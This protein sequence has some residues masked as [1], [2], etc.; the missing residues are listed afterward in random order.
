MI[1]AVCHQGPRGAR[2]VLTRL[3]LSKLREFRPEAGPGSE[4]ATLVD[5]MRNCPAR[6]TE[7]GGAA[8]AEPVRQSRAG[9]LEPS[10][11]DRAGPVR[12]SRSGPLE[13]A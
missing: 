5:P 10:R 11:S 2:A 3:S 4:I 8:G 9:P 12:Q 1:P 13:P 6:P 7:P